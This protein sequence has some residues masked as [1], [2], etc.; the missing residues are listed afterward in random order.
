MPG[1]APNNVGQTYYKL[2]EAIRSEEPCQP[3]FNAAVELHR[4]IDDMR[5]AS[6]Q[7][8]QVAVR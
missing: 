4:F 7:G 1:G 6:A 8:R 5:E 3:D 2:G